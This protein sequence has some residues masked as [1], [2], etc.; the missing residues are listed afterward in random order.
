MISKNF[1]LLILNLGMNLSTVSSV[2]NYIKL[3]IILSNLFKQPGILYT[4]EE[5]STLSLL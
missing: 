5:L 1:H 3:K 4:A 2:K